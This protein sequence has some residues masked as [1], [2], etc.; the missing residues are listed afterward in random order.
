VKPRKPKPA[1]PAAL[2]PAPPVQHEEP[3]DYPLLTWGGYGASIAG[4]FAID[5]KD[6]FA[7]RPVEWEEG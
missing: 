1:L 6:V 3:R 7:E 4:H 2:L 5:D